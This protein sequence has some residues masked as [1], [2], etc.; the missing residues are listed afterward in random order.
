MAWHF[1]WSRGRA[2]W[3][4]A[5]LAGYMLVWYCI[6]RRLTAAPIA[7]H[8]AIWLWG[9]TNAVLLNDAA[10]RV[11]FLDGWKGF[12]ST[13][14]W[15]RGNSLGGGSWLAGWILRWLKS[16]LDRLMANCFDLLMHGLK[17]GQKP[18][19]V[20][21][22]ALC[23]LLGLRLEGLL[24]LAARSQMRLRRWL[25]NVWKLIGWMAWWQTASCLAYC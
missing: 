20:Y 11:V 15:W 5:K 12:G 9:W 6:V 24:R 16:W 25:A 14:R 13:N 2:V 19:L 23:W 21:P 10:L 17:T 1:E 8:L 22:F 4:A 18:I 3:T 7:L